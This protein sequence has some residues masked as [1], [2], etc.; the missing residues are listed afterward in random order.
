MCI[1][2]SFRGVYTLKTKIACQR[3]LAESIGGTKGPLPLPGSLLLFHLLNRIRKLWMLPLI[4][5]G[6]LLLMRAEIQVNSSC[7]LDNLAF[8]LLFAAPCVTFANIFTVIATFIHVK[9]NSGFYLLL[10]TFL[11]IFHAFFTIFHYFFTANFLTFFNFKLSK[12][13]SSPWNILNAKILVL[14]PDR[15]EKV[16]LPGSAYPLPFLSISL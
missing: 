10:P 15:Y 12:Y 7:I 1:R 16:K 9:F 14:L 11:L 13:D 3:T 4:R 5:Y 8:C 6:K 2:D